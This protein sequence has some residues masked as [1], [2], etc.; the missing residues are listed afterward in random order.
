MT[1]GVEISFRQDSLLK[2]VSLE[3]I[4]SQDPR[5]ACRTRPHGP[6]RTPHSKEAVALLCTLL[7][8]F[9]YFPA[10]LERRR[11][12]EEEEEEDE[13]EEEE[14]D[15]EE[16]RNPPKSMGNKV[17]SSK[18]LNVNCVMVG[19]SQTGKTTMLYNMRLQEASRGFRRTEGE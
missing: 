17:G 10:P 4:S 5:V 16:T 9:L 13:E 3:M 8:F 14:D 12:L 2:A 18:K 15:E 6:P 11:W 1:G 19:A 7:R